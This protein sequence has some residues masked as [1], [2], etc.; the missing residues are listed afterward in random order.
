MPRP[1]ATAAAIAVTA[2]STG[3]APAAGESSDTTVCFSARALARIRS[4]RSRLGAR[5]VGGDGERARDLPER[6]EL[7]LALRRSSARW[8]LERVPLGRLERVECVAGG[9]LVNSGVP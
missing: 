6:R 8:S 4:R 7:L 1:I 5:A 3:R 2:A 9:Q